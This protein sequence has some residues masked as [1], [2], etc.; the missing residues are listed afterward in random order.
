[1]EVFGDFD[2]TGFSWAEERASLSEAECKE[3]G[4]K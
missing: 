4:E 2:E 3:T 1:M